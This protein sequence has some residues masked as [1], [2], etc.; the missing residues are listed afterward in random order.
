ME[1]TQTPI[2]IP[3]SRPPWGIETFRVEG[4][5]GFE[6][7]QALWDGRWVVVS[8]VLAEHAEIALAVE[9]ALSDAP[10]TLEHAHWEAFTRPERLLLALVTC[11]DEIDVVEF[12]VWGERRVIASDLPDEERRNSSSL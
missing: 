3:L 10:P 12:D 11:C 5:M 4:T 9:D 7:V 1:R 2:T 8:E 6:P